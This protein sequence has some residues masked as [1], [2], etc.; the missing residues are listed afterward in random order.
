MMEDIPCPSP[1]LP[2]SFHSHP[3]ESESHLHL[4]LLSTI[5][6]PPSCPAICA[7][8]FVFVFSGKGLG[9]PG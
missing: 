9:G 7:P 1:I 4:L 8:V 5:S 2:P 3:P 6:F